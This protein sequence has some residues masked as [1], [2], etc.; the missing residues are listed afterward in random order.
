MGF[1]DLFL[2]IR[3]V[4]LPALSCLFFDDHTMGVQIGSA[5]GTL[6]NG[7][8]NGLGLA[9]FLIVE[10]HGKLLGIDIIGSVA[11]LRSRARSAP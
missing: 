3:H 5:L 9:F 1:V 11:V 8:G 10:L 4:S 6:N 2:L 7:E